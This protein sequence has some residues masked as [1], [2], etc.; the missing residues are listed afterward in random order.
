MLLIILVS[1]VMGIVPMLIYSGALYWLDRWEKEPIPLLIAAFFWGLIPAIIGALIVEVV[2]DIPIGAVLEYNG[3]A[4]DLVTAGFVAPV[5]EEGIKAVAVLLIFIFFYNEFDSVLDGIIYGSLAG[6][7]FAAVENVLYFI[8]AG[9]DNPSSLG[10]LIFM[11]AFLFGLNHAFFTSLT[12]IG[13]AAARFQK[14]MLLKLLLPLVGL[15]C[16]MTAHAIHNSL[17]TFQLVPLAILADW[18]GTFIVF[19]IAIGSLIR[20][21]AWIRRYLAE[22]VTRGVITPAQA[23]RTASFTGR[24]ASNFTSLAGG[25]A[26]WLAT[27]R[28][29]QLST[30]LAYKKHQFEKAGSNDGIAASIERL[31]GEVARLSPQV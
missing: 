24:I 4:H 9:A 19:V 21:A 25:P 7:G 26:K 15:I 18:S 2:L 22:E 29:Y 11:R 12:G 10:F 20:E 27:R 17:A 16:A 3:L 8:G 14:N 23:A 13:F 31:R 6:F 5:V 1:I 30:E 28:F